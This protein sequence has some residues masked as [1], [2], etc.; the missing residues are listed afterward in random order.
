MLRSLSF[1]HGAKRHSLFLNSSASNRRYNTSHYILPVFEWSKYCPCDGI[2]N[3]LHS[4]HDVHGVPY[5]LGLCTLPLLTKF[6]IRLPLDLV[7]TKMHESQQALIPG[8]NEEKFESLLT[9]LQK[10]RETEPAV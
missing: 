6:L 5:I 7:C 4:L 2:E 1:Q 9:I 10:K 8:I 3:Y